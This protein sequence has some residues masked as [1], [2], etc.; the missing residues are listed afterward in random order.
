MGVWKTWGPSFVIHFL[1]AVTKFQNLLS[2]S[3]LDFDMKVMMALEGSL[4]GSDE[5][6]FVNKAQRFWS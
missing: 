1:V 5:S 6:I 3:F 4:C 2:L